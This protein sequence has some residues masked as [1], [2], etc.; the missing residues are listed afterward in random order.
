MNPRKVEQLTGT[1]RVLLADILSR[2]ISDPRLADVVINR[3][4]LASDGSFAKV[5][6]SSFADSDDPGSERI[7]ILK[8]ASGYIRKLLSKKLQV[9]VTPELRFK[10]DDS[11]KEGE[12]VLSL[13][14]SLNTEEN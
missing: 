10:W 5:F 1:I 14:R 4:E 11:V 7:K 8:K 13:L 9:R 6:V 3:I 2:E 12:Q